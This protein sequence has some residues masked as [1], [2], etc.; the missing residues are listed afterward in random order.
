[1]TIT[2]ATK[3]TFVV[4]SDNFRN[5]L[6]LIAP[7]SSNTGTAFFGYCF[8]NDFLRHYHHA[9]PGVKSLW[10]TY[11]NNSGVFCAVHRAN[12]NKTIIFTDPLGQ[13][14]V[15]YYASG[16]Q[17]FIS[18]DFWLTAKLTSG[19]QI[20]GDCAVDYVTYQSPVN[21]ET[22]AKNVRRLTSHEAVEVLD[23]QGSARSTLLRFEPAKYEGSYDELLKQAAE[24]FKVRAAAVLR[25]GTPVVH[26]SGGGDSRL[27]FSALAACGYKGPVFSFGDGKS[28]DRLV[29]QALVEKL[30]LET[31]TVK[32]FNGKINNSEKFLKAVIAFNGLKTNNFSNWGFG[33]D[34]SH[35]EVT[36][37]FGEGLLK[38]FGA[39]WG[40]N[41]SL[42]LF[43]YARTVSAF[44]ASVFDSAEDRIRPEALEILDQNDGNALMAETDFYLR[45]RS[46][47]HFGAHS[48]V[49][50]RKFQSIDLIYDPLLPNLMRQCSYSEPAIKQGAI[51][52]D[53]I[54]AIH[55]EELAAFPYD[56]RVIPTYNAWSERMQARGDFCC[57][58]KIT[59]P[60]RDL[61]PL[62]A[63]V[64]D[65]AD[66]NPSGMVCD[67]APLSSIEDLNS[68]PQFNG[69]FD[70]YPVFKAVFAPNQSGKRDIERT[71]LA[72]LA[73][74]YWLLQGNNYSPKIV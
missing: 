58:S 52:I 72:T 24:R 12:E 63:R 11:K 33:N 3:E 49:N 74:T 66:P 40:P 20:N 1:M 21:Q 42:S 69:L 44:P 73:A 57:F 8:Q 70:A 37:Y 14:P 41:K 48:V 71:S 50:N 45:N 10:Q 31:G 26:L 56:G 25:E 6:N 5:S 53:L 64:H 62:G 55:S 29:Y 9:M 32:W 22:L 17:F 16:D 35:I 60:H 19:G 30:N 38:G 13:Y 46:P 51:I 59:F 28:Q 4:A 36:G 27:S 43:K 18:N 39:F 34:S 54:R 23:Q 61:A 15:F 67:P 7:A 47:A 68:H 65:L 2:L